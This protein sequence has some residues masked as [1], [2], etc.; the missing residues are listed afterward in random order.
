[1]VWDGRTIIE[2]ERLVLRTF[3]ES[4]LPEFSA[5]HADP[6]FMLY[7][8]G[9]TLERGITDGIA[10]GAQ[11]SFLTTGVGKIAV[12]RKA[13]GAFLGMAG[14]SVEDWYPD[15]LEVGWR[16]GRQYWGEGYA[17]EAGAAW[18]RH[19]F[20]VL[21]AP[22]VISV[23]DVPNRRS[24]AVM[25]RIGLRLDHEAELSDEFGAFAAVIYAIDS[26]GWRGRS[27]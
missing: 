9:R 25:E 4:D 12:E 19:A 21:D 13:D 26:D 8:G 14:L 16:I 7:I 22:R 27:R 5:F 23:A 17:S 24:I 10:A 15:D 11:R 3:R 18:V 1:M 20:E 6:E 2:T